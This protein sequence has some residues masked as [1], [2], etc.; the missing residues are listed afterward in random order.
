MNEAV[1]AFVVEAHAVDQRFGLCQ[2]EQ[3]R[4]GVSALRARRDRADF[5]KAEAE[6]GERIDVFAI[7]VETGREAHRVRKVDSHHVARAR[8]I[9][10]GRDPCDADLM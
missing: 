7:L 4:T 1:H 6:R 8:R 3:P 5:D 9:A 10:R 2:A